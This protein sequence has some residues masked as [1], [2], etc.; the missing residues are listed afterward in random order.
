MKEKSPEKIIEA[1]MNNKIKVVELIVEL[2]KA[3][4]ECEKRAA[5]YDGNKYISRY[6]QGAADAYNHVVLSVKREFYKNK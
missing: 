1:I 4:V 2:E 5:Q 3:I 6:W